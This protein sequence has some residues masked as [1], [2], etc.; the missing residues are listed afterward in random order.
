VCPSTLT[1]LLF[2]AGTAAEHIDLLRVFLILKKMDKMATTADD[3]S[4]TAR[5]II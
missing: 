1:T 3:K 2:Y 4:F 5:A